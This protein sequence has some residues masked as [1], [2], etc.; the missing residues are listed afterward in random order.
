M[1]AGRHRSAARGHP[2]FLRSPNWA[3]P[4]APPLNGHAGR[5]GRAGKKGLA[6][7]FF[8]EKDAPMAAKLQELLQETN[9]EVPG[10]LANIAARTGSYGGGGNK[11]RGGGG[12]RFGGRDFRQQHQYGASGGA[13]GGG[14]YGSGGGGGGYG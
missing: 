5:T 11:R 2:C 9:Q 4:L 3:S 10:W 14:G 12:S 7:A 6:T 13:G 8:C 1:A